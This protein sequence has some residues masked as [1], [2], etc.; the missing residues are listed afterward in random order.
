M[1]SVGPGGGNIVGP[2][3]EISVRGL[4]LTLRWQGKD[5]L[6][7]GSRGYVEAANCEADDQVDQADDQADDQVIDQEAD[8]QVAT[9]G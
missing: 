4:S 7:R 6:G 5:G 3:G 8:D 1:R 9:A 2:G